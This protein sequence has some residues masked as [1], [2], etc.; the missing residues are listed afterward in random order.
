MNLA[1]KL[2]LSRII[3]IPFFLFFLMNQ[4]G[5]LP[6]GFAA[7]E[8][9]SKWIAL[10]IFIVASLT[11][12]LDGKIARKYNMITNFGKFMDPL[13]DK[14]LVNL[15]LIGLMMLGKANIWLVMLIIARDFIISGFRLVAAEKGVVIAASIWGKVKTAAQMV[16]VCFLIADIERI[17]FVGIVLQWLVC[18]LT[19]F[20]LIDYLV[21]NRNVLKDDKKED[22]AGTAK[23]S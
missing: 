7:I 18:I 20:S 21:K 12:M 16:M 4:Q 1:N 23:E 6:F 22:E 19:L 9:Y 11:D 17:A 15:A 3:M 14:L 13:A 8:P 5:F 10:G 2:T